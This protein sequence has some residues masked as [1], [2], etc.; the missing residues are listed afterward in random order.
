MWRHFGDKMSLENWDVLQLMKE[1][2]TDCQEQIHRQQE[3][4]ALSAVQFASC[5]SIGLFL[6]KL[7]KQK[8]ATTPHATIHTNW[9]D[10][11]LRCIVIP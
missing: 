5:Q 7:I 1:V 6:Y 8:V 4:M 11:S 3:S 10:N 2:A 9:R